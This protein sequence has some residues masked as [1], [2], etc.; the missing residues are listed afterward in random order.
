VLDVQAP[1]GRNHYT[2]VNL[3]LVVFQY[4]QVATHG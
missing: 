1:L 4:I 2:A 3:H